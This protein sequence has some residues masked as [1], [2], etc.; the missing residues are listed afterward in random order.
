VLQYGQP[1]AAS[2]V[3]FFVFGACMTPHIWFIIINCSILLLATATAVRVSYVTPLLLVWQWDQLF[4]SPASVQLQQA[5]QKRHWI[6]CMLS[7]E[8]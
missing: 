1:G 8:Q 4:A 3:F 5:A 6:E 7:S 2:A